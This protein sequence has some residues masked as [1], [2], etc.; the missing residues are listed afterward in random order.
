MKHSLTN[1]NRNVKEFGIMMLALIENIEDAE[2]LQN[3]SK[4][5]TILKQV[6]QKFSAKLYEFLKYVIFTRESMNFKD[7]R[8]FILS[9]NPGSLNY[10][11]QFDNQYSSNTSLKENTDKQPSTMINQTSQQEIHEDYNNTF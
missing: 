2:I 1:I 6:K 11:Q 9:Y 10:S 4:I 5:N 7:L 3:P 8:N